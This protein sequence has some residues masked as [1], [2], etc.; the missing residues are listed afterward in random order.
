M[1]LQLV[2]L[3]ADFKKLKGFD[4]IQDKVKH[5]RE[6]LLPKWGPIVEDYVTKIK[7]KEIEPYDNP[8]FASSII[9]LFDVGQFAKGIELGFI[10]IALKQDSGL[11]RAWPKF[12][13]DEVFAWAEKESEAGRSVEP[14]FSQVFDKVA[15]E[16]RL[17][18]PLTAKF[19]KLMA[20]NLLRSGGEVKPSLCGDSDVLQQ[21]DRLLEKAAQLH[22]GV[23]VKTLR[24]RIDMRLR[25]LDGYASQDT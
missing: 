20:H 24:I 4:R 16:W 10:A 3:E 15:H 5:K 1:H 12:I 18:E 25:A 17:A 19:Y 14:Y 11:R 13:S 2:E 9:W 23:G 21:A 6:V 7:S 22:K 8:L